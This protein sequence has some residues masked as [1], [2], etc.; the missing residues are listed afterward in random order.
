[1]GIKRYRQFITEAQEALDPAGFEGMRDDVKKMI[2]KTIENSGGSGVKEFAQKYL[3]NPTETSIEGL[4]NDDQ[5]YEFWQKYENEIDELLNKIKF[6]EESPDELNA[7]GTYK[8][9]IASTQRAVAELVKML[10]K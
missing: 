9:I 5:V 8:Y 4:I 6:F 10:A 7:I 1:M 2:E 3:K